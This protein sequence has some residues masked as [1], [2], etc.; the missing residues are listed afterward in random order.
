MESIVLGGGC[1]WCLDTLY[2]SINGVTSV[3][4]GYAGGHDTAPNYYAVAAGNTGHAEVVQVT[5]NPR[6]ISLK[7]ILEV[8][9]SIHDPTTVD[10][11][12]ADVGSQYRSVV[13][14]TTAAQK[15]VLEATKIAMQMYWHDP[16]VTIIAPL[17]HF[18]PAEAEHQDYFAKN[19][20]QAYC[21]LVINPKI[22]HFKQKFAHLL[23]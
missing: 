16:I 2:R 15:T 12:G 9:W 13:L 1:F 7:T 22:A 20:N 17:A 8:F 21:Q 11:Q 4:S 14:Y 6:Q 18:Y 5:F 19:P 10:R 3:E 23:G